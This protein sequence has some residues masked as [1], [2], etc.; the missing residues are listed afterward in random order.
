MYFQI[1]FEIGF[2]VEVSLFF[3]L[4]RS[5]VAVNKLKIPTVPD[6]KL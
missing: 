5:M 4:Y 1:V 6:G 3:V 2:G